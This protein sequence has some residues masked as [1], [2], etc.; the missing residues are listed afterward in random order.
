MKTLQVSTAFSIL[1]ISFSILLE[2]DEVVSA[3]KA[4]LKLPVIGKAL[5]VSPKL[6]RTLSSSM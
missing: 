4:T 1:G 3:G 5:A 6:N 2:E